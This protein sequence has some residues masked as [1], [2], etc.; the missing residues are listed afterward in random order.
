VTSLADFTSAELIVSPLRSETPEAAIGELCDALAAAGRLNNRA[1]FYDAVLHRE[2]R[3]G[4]AIPPEWAL[5][6]ARLVGLPQLCFALGRSPQPM[7]WL[8]PGAEPVRLI[9]L[10]AVPE[11]DGLAYL[12]LISG[13][14]R[15][16]KDAARLEHLLLESDRQAMFELL[17]QIQLPLARNPLPQR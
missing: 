11:R 10:S 8:G 14:A 16:S 9:F 7:R 6:H 2:R 5:P 17:R 13:L 12:T 4:T 15:L 3:A 1:E